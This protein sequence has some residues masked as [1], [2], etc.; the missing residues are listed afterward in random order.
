MRGHELTRII[1]P[2]V[3]P[4]NEDLTI[5]TH[6]AE[7]LASR[8]AR[9][10]V[11]VFIAGTT[12]E[13]PLLMP[14]EKKRLLAAA[15]KGVGERVPLLAGSG[16]PNPYLVLQEASE[17]GSA[18]ADVLVIPPPYYYPAPVYAIEG[19]Y[20][21]LSRNLETPILVYNIPSHT[22]IHIPVDL[23]ISLAEEDNI[24]GVKA[25]VADVK[26][27][28]RLIEEAKKAYSGFHVYSGFDQ[29]LAYNILSGGD[30]GIVAGSNLTPKLH[31]ALVEALV[32]GRLREAMKLHRLLLKLDWVLEPARSVQGGIKA[33]LAFEGLLGSDLVR[34]PLPGE[35]DVS[36]R[37]V[38]ERW[39]SS[40]L[41]DYF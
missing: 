33:I 31:T 27:Q 32:D 37:E 21:W 19:F 30:G 6:G 20:R 38:I 2:M 18:G 17:L 40:G 13:M 3:T 12:G 4:Y 26:Y 29:L 39:K 5:D 25:T 24:I 8:L 36:R 34:P 23:V 22:G 16:W 10:G 11:G 9:E 15:R 14:E 28:A 41:R 35:D 7:A 1:A